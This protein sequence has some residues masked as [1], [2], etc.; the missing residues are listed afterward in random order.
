MAAAARHTIVQVSE[1][2]PTGALDPENVVTPGI[3]VN[4]I[5]R[6]DSSGAAAGAAPS[7]GGRPARGVV[8][9]AA[10]VMVTN[11]ISLRGAGPPQ[12]LS[13]NGQFRPRP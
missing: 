13:A 5:V 11:P 4:S 9:A 2:V 1:I 10:S 12:P 3:Y 7:F 8:P 6:I